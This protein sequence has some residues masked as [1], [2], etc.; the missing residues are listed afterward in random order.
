MSSQEDKFDSSTYN[1]VYYGQPDQKYNGRTQNSI[2]HKHTGQCGDGGT[3]QLP[4]RVVH[5][6]PDHIDLQN[7]TTYPNKYYCRVSHDYQKVSMLN[8]Q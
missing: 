1:N 4:A 5:T 6:S 3:D 2:L 8:A 7:Y